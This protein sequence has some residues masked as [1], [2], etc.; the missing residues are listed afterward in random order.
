MLQGKKKALSDND[1]GKAQVCQ[2]TGRDHVDQVTGR[3]QAP[4]LYPLS[5]WHLAS[6]LERAMFCFALEKDSEEGRFWDGGDEDRTGGR[7]K[8]GTETRKWWEDN[9]PQSL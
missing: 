8:E 7:E 1:N 2:A 5:D 6:G 4:M 9:S 3:G